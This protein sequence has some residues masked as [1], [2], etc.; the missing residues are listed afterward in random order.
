MSLVRRICLWLILGAT[1]AFAVAPETSPRPVPRPTTAAAPVQESTVG[2]IIISPD[3]PG[4]S[5]SPRPVPRGGI[6]RIPVGELEFLTAEVDGVAVSPRPV[7]RPRDLVTTA[8]R[9]ALVAEVAPA[10][11][12]RRQTRRGSVCRNRAIRGEEIDDITGDLSGCEVRNPVRITEIDGVVLSQASVMDCDTA[13]AL[14]E[15]IDEGIR[16]AIGMLGGGLASLNVV[17]H[18]SCRTRNSQPG[19]RISEH[20]RGRAIDIA[21][22]ELRNGTVIDVEDGWGDNVQGRV[23]RNIHESACGPFR[24]VLGPEADQ[25]HQDHIHV[26]VGRRSGSNYC[27]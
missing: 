9:G 7:P 27:R 23:L 17:S 2:L 3:V 13:E 14:Y 1:P 26:D 20:G 8:L 6:R 19:A 4:V 18:Y 21:A 22:F 25:Y 11:P 5:R 16:P 10:E 12:E 15:W 24:T